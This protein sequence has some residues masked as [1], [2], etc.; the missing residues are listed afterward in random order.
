MKDVEIIKINNREVPLSIRKSGR[1]RR[2]SLR[3]HI[4][5]GNFELVV[6]KLILKFEINRFLKKHSSW[7]EKQ[8]LK[9]EK[10]IKKKPKPKYETGDKFYYLG[11]EVELIVRPTEKKRPIA[12]IRENK[13]I[14]NLYHKISKEDGIKTVKKTLEVFYKS[15][16]EE[17]IH[18]RL[19]YFN[20]YYKLKY[21]RVT[22]RNQ[23]S[24]WGSCSIRKNLNFNWKLV[25]A[26]I[27]VL[28][29]V[30]VHEMCHLKEM[31]HSVR[32]WK[33]VSEKMPDYKM[34]RKWLR[35]NKYLLT[36]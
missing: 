17:V 26:P 6:P 16:A 3:F 18:D 23:K 9:L 21:N 35:E 11:E 1:A 29:Y 28:D 31:N 15:K 22:M 8:W 13:M 19:Q 34:Y 24:R 30:V 10:Q 33:L 27:E 7:I 14:V 2:M 4:E 12:R 32:F 36:I 25:M 5:D 20:E